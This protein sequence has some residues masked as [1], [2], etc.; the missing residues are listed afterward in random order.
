MTAQH[1]SARRGLLTVAA[2]AAF[3]L[4]VLA[5]PAGAGDDIDP[6]T[7]PVPP[8]SI[9]PAPYPP[10]R[11]AGLLAGGLVPVDVPAEDGASEDG[12]ADDGA[13]DNTTEGS[14]APDPA[15]APAGEGLTLTFE[16]DPAAGDPLP[17]VRPRPPEPPPPGVA[18]PGWDLDHL[19][20]D[21]DAP[22]ALPRPDPFATLRPLPL[23]HD[24]RIASLDGTRRP[25][26]RVP[27][28]VDTIEGDELRAWRPYDIGFLA[29]RHPN[30]LVRDGGN[31]FLQLPVIRGL[32]GDRVK[33]LTDGVWPT[34]QTLGSQGAT[35]SLWDPESTERVE[36]YHG[37]GAY[38]RAIDAPGGMINI[39]PRRPRQHGAFTADTGVR[40]AYDSATKTWRQRVE[41][42]V[43]E[44]RFAAL[45]GATYTTRG[46]RETPSGELFPSD[47]DQVAGD[48]A[49]D[50][51]LT[52][53][54]R[55]G[56]TGQYVKAYDIDSPAATGTAFADPSYER[57]FVGLTLS[58]FEVGGM[59]HGHQMSLALDSFFQDDD[60]SITDVN[61]GI[62][63]QDDVTRFNWHIEGTLQLWCGHE[64]WAEL[65]VGYAHLKRT[66][67]LLCV[68]TGRAGPI[69]G[70][71]FAVG[72]PKPIS[73][74]GPITR[75]EI[76]QCEPVTRQ[77]E[78]EELVISGL[79]EDQVHCECWDLYAGL[80]ADWW[81]VEDDR[82]DN[83]EDHLLVGGAVGYARHLNKRVSLYSNVSYGWR[84]PSIYE[85]TAT[86]IL[87]GRIVFANPD[88]DPEI[89][90]NA[91]A[92]VKASFDNRASVQ[93]AAFAHYIGDTITTLDLAGPPAA[94][95]LVNGGD[96]WLYG[97][98]LQ[99]AWR[100]IWTL[101]G[102]E[103]FGGVGLVRSTDVDL[104]DHV[105]FHYRAG[106][107]YSVPAPRG[108]RVRR[109]Y[110]EL[111]AHGAQDWVDGPRSGDSY[112]TA[113][114]ILGIGLDL[115][116]GR[117]AAFNCG[118]T[119]LL[120]EDYT[121]P[122]AALPAAGR[123]LFAGVSV[124]F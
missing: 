35:L 40:S 83:V 106:A 25:M 70:G 119:N 91:E 29:G 94:A 71:T 64:T 122:R 31:P 102:L 6:G 77:F 58:S 34:T 54:S 17:P 79:I 92:G 112:L 52:P 21:Q 12:A 61:A 96:V 19:D 80:R 66:E 44:G 8:P 88:L 72:I 33:V 59:F 124:D 101:E 9:D 15:A 23:R 62:G 11:S 104:I 69:D 103:L 90:G 98:E 38:L 73:G 81:H 45:G 49:M 2:A 67:T 78:A 41:T 110:A 111:A 120:D 32:G 95:E 65:S 53:K 60:R 20:L 46:H 113:D 27:Q 107:R 30:V 37:P 36:I 18:L 57:V 28:W 118:L 93:A 1:S 24:D 68:P 108:Y 74:S 16:F 14:G 22:L 3:A 105:P 116:C 50:Y 82:F 86:E 85:R 56:L 123:S 76:D 10:P 100:P 87:D 42:D 99:G 114:L 7:P 13:A 39:V 75:A 84:R 55:I 121:A 5:V 4:L 97:G 26:K 89:H 47:Y 51:F 43:G 117:Q 115:G 48:L 63:S 109:W